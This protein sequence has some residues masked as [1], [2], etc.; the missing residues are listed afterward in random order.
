MICCDFI[1]KSIFCSE[2][3]LATSFWRLNIFNLSFLRAQLKIY[4]FL[5]TVLQD[6]TASTYGLF[7]E[8]LIV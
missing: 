8:I 4:I 2:N 7:H 5:L 3:T 1:S 6:L